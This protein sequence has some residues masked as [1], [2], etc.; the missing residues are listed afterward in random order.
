MMNLK[1]AFYPVLLFTLIP[2]L[3]AFAAPQCP[4]ESINGTKTILSKSFTEAKKNYVE[5]R[6]L[7]AWIHFEKMLVNKTS[8]E[9]T[10]IGVQCLSKIQSTYPQ[11]SAQ[12]ETLIAMSELLKKRAIK[13]P[14]ENELILLLQK[15]LLKSNVDTIENFIASGGMKPFNASAPRVRLILA[16]LNFLKSKPEE[17]MTLFNAIVKD[18]QETKLDRGE[19]DFLYFHLKL[20]R[21]MNK[22]YQESLKL[23][24]RLPSKQTAPLNPEEVH[25]QF[26]N[27]VKLNDYENA[28]SLFFSLKS[29]YLR[30]NY[31]AD[32]YHAAATLFLEKCHFTDANAALY[33]LK[34]IYLPSLKWI[35]KSVKNREAPY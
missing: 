3:P 35:Q 27:Q 19:R 32:I 12:P 4:I 15:S 13:G 11:L 23:I 31:Y 22:A 20:G 34:Q 26:W 8:P 10:A 25:I 9:Q 33:D 6:L 17:A 14:V 1:S 21:H 30:D 18:K 24:T 2:T 28:L 7:S 16:R 5:N 29:P